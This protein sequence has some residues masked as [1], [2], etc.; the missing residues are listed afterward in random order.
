MKSKL[1]LVKPL[2]NVLNPKGLDSFYLRKSRLRLTVTHSPL[3]V[4]D[5]NYN[6]LLIL[7]PSPISSFQNPV[8]FNKGRS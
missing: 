8:L 1:H 5:P 7:Q 3:L 2:I 4:R 6:P